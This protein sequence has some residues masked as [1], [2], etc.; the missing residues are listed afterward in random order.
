[1]AMT[2]GIDLAGRGTSSVSNGLIRAKGRHSL[3]IT[4]GGVIT[5][6]IP[7]LH[8][9]NGRRDIVAPEV[10]VKV[11]IELIV[12]EVKLATVEKQLVIGAGI[13]VGLGFAVSAAALGPEI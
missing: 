5:I 2:A 4:P 1:M 6:G 8:I 10:E 11:A 7:V 9:M 13:S 12:V 3:R